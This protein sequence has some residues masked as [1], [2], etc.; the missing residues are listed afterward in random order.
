MNN[1]NAITFL[2]SEIAE[3]RVPL[4]Y[5]A[6]IQQTLLTKNRSLL[7]AAHYQSLLDSNE[8]EPLKQAMRDLRAS[9]ATVFRDH[10]MYK[11]LFREETI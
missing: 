11:H 4:I 1:S 6:A 2:L 9:Q 3:G 8:P 5:R 7:R 10:R